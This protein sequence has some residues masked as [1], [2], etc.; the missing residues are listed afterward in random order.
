MFVFHPPVIANE[1][2]S[3]NALLNGVDLCARTRSAMSRDEQ[4]SGKP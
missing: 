3:Q 2:T 1:M 4:E